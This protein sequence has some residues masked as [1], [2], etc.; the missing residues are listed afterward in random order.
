MGYS[1]AFSFN[2]PSGSCPRCGGLGEIRELDI[3]KLVDFDKSLN[4]EDT[5][6]HI[7]FGKGG[8]AMGGDIIFEGTPKAMAEDKR[9]VTGPYLRVN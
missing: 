4:D 9:S 5:I 2:H 3:H 8:G 7:A 1:D 6:H